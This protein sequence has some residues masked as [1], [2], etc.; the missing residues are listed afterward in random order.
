MRHEIV[1]ISILGGSG[2][3]GL[4]M[5]KEGLERGHELF[6]LVR[7]PEKLDMKSEN[8]HL[9]A[10]QSTK[11]DDVRETLKGTDAVVIALNINRQSDLPWAK[12][13]SPKDLISASVKNAIQVM[14]EEGIKRI[15]S[16]SAYGVGDTRAKINAFGRAFLFGTNIKYAYIDHERQ[17]KLIA[18]SNLDWTIIRPV[19]LKGGDTIKDVIASVNGKPKPKGSVIRRN[20]ARFILNCAETRSYINEYVTLSGN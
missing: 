14:Q 6:A 1:K 3:T 2:R 9:I 5:L 15:I 10:G 18:A 16:I 8:L 20:L 17:E 4:W 11:L 12:V 7:S 13:T 19:Y